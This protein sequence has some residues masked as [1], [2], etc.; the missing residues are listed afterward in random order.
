MKI[1]KEKE[2]ETKIHK[3][4]DGKIH[5]KKDVKKN[6]MQTSRKVSSKENSAIPVV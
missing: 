2:V 6:T 5:K 3:K 4:Q 1:D